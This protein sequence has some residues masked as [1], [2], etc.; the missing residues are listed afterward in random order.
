MCMGRLEAR[1]R[2]NGGHAYSQQLSDGP[3]PVPTTGARG[4]TT[5]V[6]NDTGSTELGSVATRQPSPS[7]DVCTCVICRHIS[8]SL[9]IMI[10]LLHI[11]TNRN[12]Q[13]V[14]HHHQWINL[15]PLLFTPNV[16]LVYPSFGFL[17][18]CHHH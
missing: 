13:L 12:Q 8:L 6:P 14:Q 18:P 9:V 15:V 2:D 5:T 10:M 16:S 7:I 11:S 3:M 17:H 1:A 4:T